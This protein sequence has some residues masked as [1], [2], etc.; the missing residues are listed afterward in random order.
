MNPLPDGV[1]DYVLALQ[2]LSPVFMAIVAGWVTWL[3]RKHG[4]DLAEVKDQV[5]NTHK[6]NLREDMD[7]IHNEIREMRQENRQDNAE[8]RTEVRELRAENRDFRD[9]ETEVR[10]LVRR[11]HPEESL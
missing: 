3:K 5:K 8:L 2:V 1:S 4:Q 9:F 11:V 10:A 6:T 7:A